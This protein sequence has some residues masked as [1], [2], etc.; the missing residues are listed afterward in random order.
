MTDLALP[1]P[2]TNDYLFSPA[3]PPFG[4]F[5]SFLSP[6]LCTGVKRYSEDSSEYAFLL[7]ENFYL[8]TPFGTM[9][10]SGI[11][12]TKII[13]LREFLFLSLLLIPGGSG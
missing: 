8:T 9:S 7:V 5:F 3:F 6:S 13:S 4:L 10:Y 2:P 1:S 11:F 12:G